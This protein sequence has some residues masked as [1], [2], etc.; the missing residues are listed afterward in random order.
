MKFIKQ[1]LVHFRKWRWK[2]LL[3]FFLE[4]IRNKE[5]DDIWSQDIAM[6]EG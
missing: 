5:T 3:K 6:I 4:A 1:I 2:K